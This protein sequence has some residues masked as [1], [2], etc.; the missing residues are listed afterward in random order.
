MI[1]ARITP[2]VL[3]SYLLLVAAT[4]EEKLDVG[5]TAEDLTIEKREQLGDLLAQTV[6]SRPDLFPLLNRS[7]KS[8]TLVLNYLQTMYNQV[9][10]QLRR[11]SSS[12]GERWTLTRPWQTYV[13][14]APEPVAYSLPGGHFFISTGFLETLEHGHELY[15]LMAFEAIHVSEAYLADELIGAFG[16]APLLQLL[17]KDEPQ[18]NELT[19]L[20][21]AEHLRFDMN[22]E[23]DIVREIDRKTA[24]LICETSIFDRLGIRSILEKLE[25]SSV[26][27]YRQSRPSY[28][29]RLAF[30][31]GL[32]VDDCGSVKSTGLYWELVRKNL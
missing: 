11:R 14:D 31:D 32:P 28:Q 10:R 17:K 22:L 29:N 30:I 19:L 23:D 1:I 20:E 25:Q 6:I 13:L 5:P 2:F 9:T 27:Q 24:P 12:R 18:P 8:D 15:Y 26:E 7:S 16:T 4:C 3:L 21:L